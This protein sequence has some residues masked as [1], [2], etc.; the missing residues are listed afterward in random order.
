MRINSEKAM[1]K[2]IELRRKSDKSWAELARES[3]ER[4]E[5]RDDYMPRTAAEFAGG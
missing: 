2:A 5:A 4:L 3:R 1:I